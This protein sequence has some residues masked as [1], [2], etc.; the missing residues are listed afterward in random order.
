MNVHNAKWLRF[1]D[2]ASFEGRELECVC[3]ERGVK[4]PVKS[5]TIGRHLL[6]LVL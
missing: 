6:E 3:N 1:F 2:E 5:Q 4:Q